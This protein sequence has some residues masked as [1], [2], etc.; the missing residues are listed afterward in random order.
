MIVTMSEKFARLYLAQLSSEGVAASLE[1]YHQSNPWDKIQDVAVIVVPLNGYETNP[2]ALI[3]QFKCQLIKEGYITNGPAARTG[4][5][6]MVP[7]GNTG[8]NFA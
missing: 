4:K 3:E 5:R 6:G 7:T 8:P 1:V 2:S